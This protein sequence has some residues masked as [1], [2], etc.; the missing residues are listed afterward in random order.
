VSWPVLG[1]SQNQGNIPSGY[2]LGY[3]YPAYPAVSQNNRFWYTATVP[4][5]LE[6]KE[7]AKEPETL[8]QFFHEEI[9]RTG[10]SFILVFNFPQ[11]TGTGHPLILKN[12]QK[13]NRRFFKIQRIAKHWSWAG[14]G[15][16][17]TGSWVCFRTPGSY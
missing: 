3:I 10:G 8:Y 4:N 9:T 15:I 17:T 14:T 12:F 13:W 1:G 11:R 7:L 2:H 16:S 6:V 5:F